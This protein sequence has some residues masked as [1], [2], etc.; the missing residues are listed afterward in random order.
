V[1]VVSVLAT[2]SSITFGSLSY[3]NATTFVNGV[4]K[5]AMRA[6]STSLDRDVQVI[7]PIRG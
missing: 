1:V 3:T 6:L 5:I 7:R 4:H 2:T